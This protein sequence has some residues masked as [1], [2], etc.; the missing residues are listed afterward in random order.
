MFTA[1]EGLMMTKTLITAFLTNHRGL[2][3]LI[4]GGENIF[5]LVWPDEEREKEEEEE[6]RALHHTRLRNRNSLRR[7]RSDWW[8]L[9]SSERLTI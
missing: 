5:Q 3:D 2:L 4:I 8:L 1:E 7:R 9:M 6:E